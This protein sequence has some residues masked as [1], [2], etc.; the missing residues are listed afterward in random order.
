MKWALAQLRKLEKPFKFEYDFDLISS[1]VNANDVL[2]CNK[3]HIDG[4]CYELQYDEY[5]FD[6]NFD[7]ELIMC[8]A[9]SLEEVLVPLK[10]NTQVRFS[11]EV[12]DSSDDYQIFKETINLDDAVLSEIVL[13]IP[14]RVVK[15]GYENQFS[16]EEE[17]DNINPSFQI[18]KDLYGGEE[19]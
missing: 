10:F 19:K 6:L 18:L 11:R 15:D 3:C 16:S 9:V 5:M 14:F 8:C 2:G 17:N 1:L 13:N 12:D 4:I 7:L